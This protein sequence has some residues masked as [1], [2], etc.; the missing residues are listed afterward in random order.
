MAR[1]R[2]R[3]SAKAGRSSK[4][5]AERDHMARVRVSEEVWA[6]FRAA[7]GQAPL[8]LLLGKLVERE[9]DRYRSKRLREGTLDDAQLLDALERAA[10]LQAD[11][12]ALV[13]RLER[14]L[15][16]AARP[17]PGGGE[18]EEEEWT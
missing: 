8:N 18:R 1:R 10:E 14:R 2:K 13:A 9:V 4:P 11:L 6:D 16:R 17:R 5:A 12:A 7:A 15:D 3:R